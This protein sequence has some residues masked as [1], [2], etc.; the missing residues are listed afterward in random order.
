M[1]TINSHLDNVDVSTTLGAV[2][3]TGDGSL[4]LSK[5]LIIDTLANSALTGFSPT[6]ITSTGSNKLAEI[7]E[8]DTLTSDIGA[9]AQDIIN[10]IFGAASHPD[11]VWVFSVDLVGGST[12]TTAIQALEQVM[13]DYYAVVIADSTLANIAEI[14]TALAGNDIRKKHIVFAGL[15]DIAVAGVASGSW[16]A[17]AVGVLSTAI[18]DRLFVTFHDGNLTTCADFAEAAALY[19]TKDPEVESVG[20]N[21]VLTTIPEMATI[22]ATQ[23]GYLDDNDINH[24]LPFFNSRTYLDPGNMQSGRPI[25]QIISADWFENAVQMGFAELKEDYANR[26]RKVPLDSTG[27]ALGL[28]IINGIYDNAVRAGHFLS[29]QEIENRDLSAKVIRAESISAGDIAAR[30]LR[31]TVS[32]YFLDDA[33]EFQI[34][35]YLTS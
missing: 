20:G 13:N 33:R 29:D 32:G 30:R 3:G 2:A 21:L 25:Y 34:S 24:A 16:D 26:R 1:T 8:S 12:R 4:Q 23:Q 11:S 22:T 6:T 7:N 18:K 10:A 27:Q 5:I 17:N 35:I 19:L 15:S 9:A 28:A 14:C 31:F